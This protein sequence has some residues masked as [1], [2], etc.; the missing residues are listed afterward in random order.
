VPL[1]SE[2]GLPLFRL[3]RDPTFALE[4]LDHLSSRLRAAQARLIALEPDE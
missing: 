4:M 1:S 2:Y 3:R